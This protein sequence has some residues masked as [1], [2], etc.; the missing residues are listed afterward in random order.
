MYPSQMFH[1]LE[2]GVRG[3]DLWHHARRF[4]N[5]HNHLR[6]EHLEYS[7]DV[8]HFAGATL[9][10]IMTRPFSPRIPDFCRVA[11]LMPISGP[12]PASEN[13]V[14][15]RAPLERQLGPGRMQEIRELELSH[16]RHHERM[17]PIVNDD[18]GGTDRRWRALCST[19]Y[20][21]SV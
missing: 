4:C 11:F 15:D 17:V 2:H 8:E 18:R 1:R 14:S 20:S 21:L 6:R 7:V 9:E 16:A 12:C 5:W 10:A 13:K 19:Q 3:S